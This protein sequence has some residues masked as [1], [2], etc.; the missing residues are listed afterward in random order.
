MVAGKEKTQRRIK[1]I[2]KQKRAF[3]NNSFFGC[4]YFFVSKST[5]CQILP[6]VLTNGKIMVTDFLGEC[7]IN[8]F[9]GPTFLYDYQVN[10]ETVTLQLNYETY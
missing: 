10:G 7:Q 4:S 6:W 8:N 1:D 9:V 2:E 5:K 3:K